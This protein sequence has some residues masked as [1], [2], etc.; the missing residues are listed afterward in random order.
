MTVSIYP[1]PCRHA[2]TAHLFSHRLSCFIEG[3]RCR[4][5][6]SLRRL[7]SRIAHFLSYSKFRRLVQGETRWIYD[8][9]AA[10]AR[11]L[12]EEMPADP[13]EF[14]TFLSR[15]EMPVD[16][17]FTE[18]LV[19][20]FCHP[21]PHEVA[22]LFHLILRLRVDASRSVSY[23]G[24]PLYWIPDHLIAGH[25]FAMGPSARRREARAEIA[26]A[27]RERREFLERRESTRVATLVLLSRSRLESALREGGL[28]PGHCPHERI[29]I[30]ESIL[31]D[32]IRER[33]LQV[34]IVEDLLAD[35]PRG[36]FD[37][38][39]PFRIITAVDDQLVVKQSRDSFVRVCYERTGIAEQDKRLEYELRM[40]DALKPWDRLGHS[41]PQVIDEL[42]RYLT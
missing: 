14:W 7:H 5:G 28:L 18:T 36:V 33:Q 21:T 27:M 19:G 29:E 10:V 9:A 26:L 17:P 25:V 1:L 37:H 15:P 41:T 3:Y 11:P 2:G 6:C 22:A 32:G 23:G 40:L 42:E 31:N 13:Q 35:F 30:F 12:A 38:F 20:R 4:Y 16:S 39:H 24:I 34:G 8:D